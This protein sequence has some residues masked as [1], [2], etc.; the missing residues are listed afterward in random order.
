M[1]IFK[2]LAKFFKIVLLFAR[3][4]GSNLEVYKYIYVYI[5]IYIMD[6]R[7][8]AN[9]FFSFSSVPKI[10]GGTEFLTVIVA[11]FFLLIL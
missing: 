2:N 7:C 4:I 6:E 1:Y 5:Y 8:D 10:V 3:L 11:L 9:F